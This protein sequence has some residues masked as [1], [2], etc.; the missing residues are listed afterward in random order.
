MSL[1]KSNK[2]TGA[3]P[4]LQALLSGFIDYAGLFPP[5]KLSLSSAA[6]NY[7]GYALSDHSWMLRWFVLPAAEVANVPPPLYGRLSVLSGNSL[8]AGDVLKHAAAVE[9]T[10][11]VGANN[12]GKPVYCQVDS[13]QLPL[14]EQIKA[15]GCF[16][17]V[18]MGGLVDDDFPGVESAACFINA[19]A[20]QRL[21]FKATAGLHHPLRASYRLTYEANSP[22]AVMHGFINLALAAALAWHGHRD[23]EPVLAEI[24]PSAFHFGSEARWRDSS[25]SLEQI[26]DARRNFL[27]AIGS[28]SF[29][30]PVCDLEKLGWLP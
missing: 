2:S 30:E 20:E 24:D 29:E 17:K 10:G 18:R 25:L 4:A 21:A 3:A 11:P 8:P 23:I 13:T 28:C 1:L 7:N 5:A 19:C 9:A 26:T 15:N 14:L 16:A 27:H 6:G 12:T 22:Q